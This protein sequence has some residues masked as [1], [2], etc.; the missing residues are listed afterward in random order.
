MG[1]APA[2]VRKE[3]VIELPIGG[4]H[5]G[6]VADWLLS[7][8]LQQYLGMFIANGFDDIDFLVSRS[9]LFSK[10]A[11]FNLNEMKGRRNLGRCES[12]GDRSARRSAPEPT[13]GGSQAAGYAAV[14][15]GFQ[16]SA[17]QSGRLA[18]SPPIGTLR[19][20]VSQKLLRR[21]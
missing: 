13:D 18:R 12:D 5:D 17:D 19:R 20:A 16:S 2:E 3:D 7:L 1:G 15:N 11:D 9:F 8:G 4:H 10:S 6:T 14:Q 21:H